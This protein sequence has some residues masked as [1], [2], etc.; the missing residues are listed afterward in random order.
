MIC[1]NYVSGNLEIDIIAKSG[2]KFYGRYK[3]YLTGT[4]VTYKYPTP[5]FTFYDTS[6]CGI[7]AG[8]TTYLEYA[9]HVSSVARDIFGYY[10]NSSRSGYIIV[11]GY[12]TI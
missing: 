6:Y 3:K 10:S 11:Q 12:I 5:F 2:C 9:S 8:G 1:F 7:Y 4:N